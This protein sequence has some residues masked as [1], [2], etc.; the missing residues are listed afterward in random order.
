MASK[1]NLNDVFANVYS[2]G[3]APLIDKNIF[4]KIQ[5]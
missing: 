3:R 5:L 2:G 1:K 4:K